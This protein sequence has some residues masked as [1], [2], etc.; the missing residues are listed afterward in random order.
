MS[1]SPQISLCM[2]VRNEA[3]RL[4]RCLDSVRDLVDEM[5]VLDTGSTDET[6]AIAQS[7]GATVPF[8]AWNDD[9][10]AA[11]NVALEHVTGDWVLVLDADET[12]CEAVIPPIRQSIAND[13][14]I[15]INLV[16]QEIGADQ[17]PYSLVSRLFRRHPAVHFDRPYHALIDDSVLALKDRE[18]HWQITDLPMVAIAHAG[19]EPGTIAQQ[20]KSAR[21]QAALER[22]LAEHPED[23]YAHSKLGAI[24]VQAGDFAQGLDILKRGLKLQEQQTAPNPHLAYELH[25]H[26]GIA[27]ARQA[28]PELALSHYRVALKQPISDRL[29]LGSAINLGNLL[30]TTGNLDAARQMYETC[31]GI[32]SDFPLAHF[33]LGTVLRAM[34]NPQ[35]AIAHYERAIQLAPDYAEAHQNLGVALLKL[36]RV[37]DSLKAFERAI[38][39]HET[40]NPQEAQRIR[41]ELEKL[42]FQV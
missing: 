39:L 37:R 6:V 20:N 1:S 8:Y 10:A 2:I 28:L 17:S 3:E 22:Y 27:R 32:D 40:T 12:L 26:L 11:R 24:Y 34:G 21:A 25:Y 16:R 19:Y 15:V 7:H 38:A 14:L 41:Q 31:I 9:F 18:P 4:S 33:N 29:K 35:Q 36:G 30:K 13:N 23:V 5:V 42:Q